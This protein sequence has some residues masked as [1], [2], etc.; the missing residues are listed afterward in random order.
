MTTFYFEDKA[1]RFILYSL[2]QW[3]N[4]KGPKTGAIS[5]RPGFLATTSVLFRKYRKLSMF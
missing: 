3:K 1:Y 4:E 2:V 5:S